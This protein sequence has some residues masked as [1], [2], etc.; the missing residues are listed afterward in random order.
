MGRLGKEKE[1]EIFYTYA[2][3]IKLGAE[4]LMDTAKFVTT[5]GLWI[6]LGIDF[7]LATGEIHADNELLFAQREGMIKMFEML[8]K[9]ATTNIPVIKDVNPFGLLNEFAKPFGA[10]LSFRIDE[11][12]PIK[13]KVPITVKI[14]MITNL[15]GKDWSPIS[16]FLGEPE[17]V[18]LPSGAFKTIYQ[19]PYYYTA[20]PIV[21]RIVIAAM[22]PGII[23]LIFSFL[24]SQLSGGSA[25]SKLL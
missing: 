4:G 6:G 3:S 2:E 21:W 22:M 19:Q 24:S 9:I 25:F 23:R 1:A 11:G 7:F 13:K 17:D 15:F 14:P 5:E 10:A 16:G 12:E 20:L 8:D 18:K